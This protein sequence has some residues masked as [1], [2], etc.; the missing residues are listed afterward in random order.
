MAK[1][2]RKK[3][4]NK[5]K[6]PP[7]FT[8]LPQYKT[9]DEI[10][11]DLLINRVSKVTVSFSGGHDEGGVD[12]ITLETIEHGQVTWTDLWSKETDYKAIADALSQPVYDEYY[13]FAGEFHVNGQVVWDA[14]TREIN[15]F[16]TEEVSTDQPID[17]KIKWSPRKERDYL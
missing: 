10:W 11:N 13:S 2:T 17:K 4:E 3:K 12:D 14:N 15:M 9:V 1:T 7:K 5:K 8:W 6:G 16:G